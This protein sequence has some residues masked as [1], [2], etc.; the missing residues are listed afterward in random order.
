MSGRYLAVIVLV[1]VIAAIHYFVPVTTVRLRDVWAGAFLTAL[2][3]LAASS[4]FSWYLAEMADLSIHGS[5]ATVVTFLFWVYTSAVIFFVRCGV[6]RRLG[7]SPG[8][9]VCLALKLQETYADRV[10]GCPGR[11]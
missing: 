9:G 5:I 1:G 2:L 6:Y 3:W 11:V 7:A 4:A 8:E 10:S